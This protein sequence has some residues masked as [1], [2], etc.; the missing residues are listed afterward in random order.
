MRAKG[1]YMILSCYLLIFACPVQAWTVSEKPIEMPAGLEEELGEAPAKE[2]S[3]LSKTPH[4]DKGTETAFEKNT[5]PFSDNEQAML[6]YSQAL[7]FTN[8][9]RDDKAISLLTQTVYSYPTHVLSRT[10]L[11][12]LYLKQNRDNE[13]QSVLEEGLKYTEDHPDLLKYLAICFER[14]NDPDNAL[15]CL[16]K[17]PEE[18]KYDKTTVALAAHIYQTTG[19]YSLARQQYFRLLQFEPKNT[20]WLL[21]LSIAFDSEGNKDA[22][23]EGYQK[24]KREAGIDSSLLE[25]VNTRIQALNG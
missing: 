18:R 1:L 9:G 4:K 22:A 7:E 16:N 8:Q 5:V 15:Q 12:R 13:A 21:G 24:V 23:L 10:E 25:Y 2:R 6:D 14:Q 3:S 17:I 19:H 11:A 20:L